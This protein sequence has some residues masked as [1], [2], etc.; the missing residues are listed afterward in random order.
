MLSEAPSLGLNPLVLLMPLPVGKVVN[1][2]AEWTAHT[3]EPCAKPL[4]RELY[5][6]SVRLKTYL[7][8]LRYFQCPWGLVVQGWVTE[9]LLC[10]KRHSALTAFPGKSLSP[11]KHIMLAHHL[12][13]VESSLLHLVWKM[14]SVSWNICS[15]IWIMDLGIWITNR[16]ESNA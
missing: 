4:G 1:S 2:P 16:E 12:V 14:C 5:L 7:V 15:G 3:L 11:F 9:I 13:N 8:N 6:K 10:I